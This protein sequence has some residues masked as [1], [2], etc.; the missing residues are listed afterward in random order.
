MTIDVRTFEPADTNAVR[1]LLAAA[2]AG[3]VEARLVSQL[4]A[5]GDALLELVA[6]Q[7]DE[8]VGHVCFSK[9]LSPEDYVA[10]AP[11]AVRPEMQRGG[12][13]S[14]LIR[15]GIEDIERSGFNGIVLLGEPA[16]YQRFGFRVDAAAPLDSD[17]PKAYLQA[18]LFRK[19]GPFVSG[20]PLTYAAAF[21]A[22]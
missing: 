18:L 17:Y 10:L 19:A 5:D 9:L 4:R 16:Y 12:I 7:G 11:V 20:T 14:A 3:D 1:D 13:G 15:R 21:G 22:A 6:V 8:L 2:F